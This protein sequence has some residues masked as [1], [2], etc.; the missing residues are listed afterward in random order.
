MKT[1][2]AS[3]NY[4]FTG[5]WRYRSTALILSAILLVCGVITPGCSYWND[6]PASS[7]ETGNVEP[8]SLEFRVLAH[9]DV[10]Q[11]LVDLALASEAEQ[12]FAP[13]TDELIGWWLPVMPK[14]E[15]KFPEPGDE[16]SDSVTRRT[17]VDVLEVLVID[18]GYNVTG[19]KHF[20]SVRPDVDSGME[21]CISFT[22]NEPGSRLFEQM[23][24][25]HK[26][27]AVT[28][29]RRQLAIVLNG[30]IKS[31]PTINSVIRGTGQITGD[32]TEAEVNGIVAVLE[33]GSLPQPISEPVSDIEL[34]NDN[35][36][37]VTWAD[38]PE[39]EPNADPANENTD[40]TWPRP[41]ED[42]WGMQGGEG[43][44]SY[45]Q[46]RDRIFDEV[47]EPLFENPES[48]VQLP[49]GDPVYLTPDRKSVIFL[50]VVCQ[51]QTMLEMFICMRD[52]T[53]HE[54]AIA[55]DVRPFLIH[56]G[57]LATGAEPGLPIQANPTY[58]P[59]TGPVV[60]ILLRWKGEEGETQEMKAQDW[61]RNTETGEA[62]TE[63]WVWTG[64]YMIPPRPEPETPD[65]YHLPPQSP[66]A[67]DH[68]GNII[69]VANFPS[70]IMDLPVASSDSN[71][72]L[73]YETFAEHI[74]PDGT[75]ITVVLTPR[76]R[77]TP[78]EETPTEEST[79]EEE[80]TL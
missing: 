38:E 50:G 28:G 45:A 49:G 7:P 74:P 46:I 41:V 66:F 69:T 63:S 32:F 73:S 14:E 25:K 68:S 19:S 27:D 75:P 2:F 23:T 47:G 9:R 58:L 40:D 65:E 79:P 51:R 64:S 35:E 30:R 59:P 76:Q 6:D 3:R 33:A 57:L 36:P 24:N 70:A 37:E 72:C 22:L 44:E 54:S 17:E 55:A 10:D 60:D 18:D 1:T 71:N 80:T 5:A 78:A 52:T 42:P 56:A 11:E 29:R 67:A 21:R 34:P 4:Y 62:M 31:A 12:V 39:V 61:I 26:P 13:G 16:A 43:E 53:E 15:D 77:E 8:A 48:L 20:E